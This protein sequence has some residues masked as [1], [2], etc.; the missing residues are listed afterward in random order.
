MLLVTTTHKIKINP[1]SPFVRIRQR[2]LYKAI[3]ML[4]Q[5]SRDTPFETLVIHMHQFQ[6]MDCGVSIADFIQRASTVIIKFQQT[7]TS[8]LAI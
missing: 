2:K 1:N 3:H 7:S 6:C 4:K 5:P 8:S